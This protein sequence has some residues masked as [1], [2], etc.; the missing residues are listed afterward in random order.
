MENIVVS[1]CLL[2][3]NCKYNGGNNLCTELLKLRDKYNFIPICPET[4]GGLIS[5]RE[6]AEIC[7]KRVTLKSGEDVTKA[8]Y[9]GAEKSL[10]IVKENGCKCVFAVFCGGVCVQRT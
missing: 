5:P 1:A 4:F 10:K 2:G 7:G 8:F 3:E 9:D 6:P